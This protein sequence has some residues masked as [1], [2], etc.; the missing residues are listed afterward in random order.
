MYRMEGSLLVLM[1][2]FCRSWD[3]RRDIPGASGQYAQYAGVSGVYEYSNITV[4]MRV[5]DQDVCLYCS[6]LALSPF[7]GGRS[8]LYTTV[9]SPCVRFLFGNTGL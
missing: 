7:L 8:P 1:K 3:C 4:L 6:G 9:S 5:K 2:T